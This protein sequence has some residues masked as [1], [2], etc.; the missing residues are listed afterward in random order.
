MIL[1]PLP[2]KKNL[3]AG[4][5]TVVVNKPTPDDFPKLS[6]LY[7]TQHSPPPIKKLEMNLNWMRGGGVS[8]SSVCG[9]PKKNEKVARI[10]PSDF[11]WQS[12]QLFEKYKL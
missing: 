3:C 11:V 8:V 10:R 12:F 1:S 4:F 9:G 2:K 5:L 7:K 6:K